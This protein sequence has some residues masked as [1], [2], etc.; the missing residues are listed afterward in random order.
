MSWN[1][2]RYNMDNRYITTSFDLEYDQFNL[3]LAN[4]VEMHHVT[5]SKDEEKVYEEKGKDN[6]LPLYKAKLFDNT[7]DFDVRDVHF[8]SNNLQ[9]HIDCV[10]REI[11]I[12]EGKTYQAEFHDI[13]TLHLKEESSVWKISKIITEVTKTILS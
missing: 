9:P 7:Q 2:I 5:K 1:T 12:K 8:I 4:D 3:L 6:I 10:V 11:K 13:T